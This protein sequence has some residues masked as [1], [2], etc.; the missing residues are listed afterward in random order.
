MAN[1]RA[2][3]NVFSIE[4][5]HIVDCT[6]ITQNIELQEMI[7]IF[8]NETMIESIGTSESKSHESRYESSLP[9]AFC[10]GKIEKRLRQI[11]NKPF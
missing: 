11:S 3:R 2:E 9:V 7:T 1:H 4:K 8:L 5:L 10:H 6:I